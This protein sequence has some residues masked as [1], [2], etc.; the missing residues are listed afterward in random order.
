[1]ATVARQFVLELGDPEV[2]ILQLGR[3]ADH[4]IFK[5][6]RIIGQL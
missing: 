2:T 1:V 6:G 5:I 3:Q 4:Q